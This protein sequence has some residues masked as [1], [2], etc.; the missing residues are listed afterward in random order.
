MTRRF[1]VRVSLQQRDFWTSA[2]PDWQ[3]RYC[4]SAATAAEAL[5]RGLSI[6]AAQAGPANA[7]LAVQVTVEPVM[8]RT[9][10]T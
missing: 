4:L 2:A 1:L 5:R 7:G 3:R 10:A 8:Q 9:R 6:A